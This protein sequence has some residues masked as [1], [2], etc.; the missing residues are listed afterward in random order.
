[1]KALIKR[2]NLM[3]KRMSK[4]NSQKTLKGLLKNPFGDYKE[5]KSFNFKSAIIFDLARSNLKIVGRRKSK[6]KDR[7]LL[8]Q[9]EGFPSIF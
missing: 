4:R 2:L 1:M 3:Y 9:M 8:L 7:K 6:F 5:I